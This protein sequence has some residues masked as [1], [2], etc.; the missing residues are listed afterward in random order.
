MSTDSITT[1]NGRRCTKVPR[2]AASQPTSPPSSTTSVDLGDSSTSTVLDPTLLPTNIAP[3]I[4]PSA[5]TVI[6]DIPPAV[7]P[8][9]TDSVT[10][11]SITDDAITDDAITDDAITGDSVTIDPA[12]VII[13]TLT[14]PTTIVIPSPS[15]TE[16]P[17]PTSDPIES[18][19]PSQFLLP[20][21]TTSTEE[22]QTSSPSRETAQT[23]ESAQMETMEPTMMPS[24]EGSESTTNE[25]NPRQNLGP[26]IGG[27]MAAVVVIFL[28]VALFLFYRRKTRRRRI[29][30]QVIVHRSTAFDKRAEAGYFVPCAESRSSVASSIY[31]QVEDPNTRPVITDRVARYFNNATNPALS[32]MTTLRGKAAAR[33]GRLGL[34]NRLGSSKENNWQQL[35]SPT[36]SRTPSSRRFSVNSVEISNPFLDPPG[37][38]D[39]DG[40]PLQRPPTP[41]YPHSRSAR[42]L[43]RRSRSVPAVPGYPPVPHVVRNSRIESRIPSPFLGLPLNF[44]FR[45]ESPTLV[46][47][48]SFDTRMYS[49]SSLDGSVV[50]LPGVSSN[51]TSRSSHQASASD[52]S[53]WRME[54]EAFDTALTARRSDPFDLERPMSKVSGNSASTPSLDNGRA[55]IMSVFSSKPRLVP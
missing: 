32:H 51:N 38:I 36:P 47:R 44:G 31:T 26:I 23:Q 14:S 8:V 10:D 55:V 18:T 6:P 1:F 24:P 9:A 2:L 20:S 5:T 52:I 11:D 37:T 22:R 3:T 25:E 54:R 4:P 53:R 35:P 43:S 39:P 40:G 42:A 27:T 15:L 41:H 7:D 21:E 13:P 29:T 17:A 28:C 46:D 45:V 49:D 33:L 30:Q 48:I 12:P 19:V 16:S 34:G 50:M